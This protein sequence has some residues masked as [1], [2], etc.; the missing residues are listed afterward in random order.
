MSPRR[1]LPRESA[2]RIQKARITYHR[3]DVFLCVAAG[4]YL[5]AHDSVVSI[6]GQQYVGGADITNDVI[7][8]GGSLD[9]KA[10]RFTGRIGD[11]L[12]VLF[13]VP[14]GSARVRREVL[15]QKLRGRWSGAA[16]PLPT[17]LN[18]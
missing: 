4:Q 10:E 8:L 15:P 3:C 11:E 9:H 6:Q 16:M 13:P 14:A 2:I 17:A 7:A 18:V 5:Q 1:L 12:G